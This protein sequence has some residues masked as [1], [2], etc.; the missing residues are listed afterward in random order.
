M[1]VHVDT[2]EGRAT[3]CGDVIYDF[4]DQIVNPFHEIHANEPRTTGNH[5]VSKREEKA[6]IKKLLAGSKFL[7]P[8][9]DKPAKIE[10]RSGD[11]ANGHGRSRPGRAKP[12]VAQLV[13]DVSNEIGRHEQPPDREGFAMTTHVAVRPGFADL[14]RS[15]GAGAPDRHRFPVHGRA[16]LASARSYLL[17][18]DM[19]GDVRR[20]YDCSRHPRGDAAGE[21]VQ[22]HD[23]RCRAQPHRLRARDIDAR[24]RTAGRAARDARLAFRGDGA[25]QPQRCLREIGR[26]DLFLRSLVWPHAGLRR[27]AAAPAR[28]PGRLSPAARAAESRN[29]W[30]TAICSSSRT[31]S[32]SRRTRSCS[33]STIPCSS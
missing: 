6:A 10:Q 26:L 5:G 3:I 20:R 16:D 29:C 30:W 7:L 27:R 17:F 22:R 33:T 18:S 23:L 14:D 25:E 9:H 31:G 19:P 15:L 32:A 2:V 13:P 28:L 21:Q 24:A 1:N 8:I 12:A 4:N 11:R